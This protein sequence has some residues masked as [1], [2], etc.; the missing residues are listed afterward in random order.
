MRRDT[1]DTSGSARGDENCGRD[2]ENAVRARGGGVNSAEEHRTVE[3]RFLKQVSNCVT[4]DVEQLRASYVA[5][6]SNGRL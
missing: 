1:Q 2:G 4:V 6:E 3:R 5:G